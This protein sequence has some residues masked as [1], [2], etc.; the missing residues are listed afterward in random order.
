ML[1]ALR[2]ET[3]RSGAFPSVAQHKPRHLVDRQPGIGMQ[4]LVDRHAKAA[5]I[6]EKRGD[7][8]EEDALMRE[9][10]DGADIVLDGLFHR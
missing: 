9:I 4:K 5:G 8:A 7:I 6:G 2:T 3:L 1:S 10:H